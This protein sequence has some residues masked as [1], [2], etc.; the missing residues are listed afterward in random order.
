LIVDLKV[1]DNENKELKD[2]I[3]ELENKPAVI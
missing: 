1:A 3:K 2:T